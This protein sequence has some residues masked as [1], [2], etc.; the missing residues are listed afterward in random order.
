MPAVPFR[1]HPPV[2]PPSLTPT[3]QI[4][5]DRLYW[6]DDVP[7]AEIAARFGLA[8]TRIHRFATPRP[9]D[10]RC[11]ICGDVAALT[12]RSSRS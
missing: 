6:D 5:L 3:E 1:P 2:D 7:V 8:R 4:E 11:L 10:L 12:S 9:T